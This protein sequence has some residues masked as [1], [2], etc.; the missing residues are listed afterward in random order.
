MTDAEVRT[1]REC[2]DIVLCL[3]TRCYASKNVSCHVVQCK[4]DDEDN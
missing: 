2:G 3:I 4:G 1:A